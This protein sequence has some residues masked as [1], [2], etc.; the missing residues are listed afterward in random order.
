[1]KSPPRQPVLLEVCVASVEDAQSAQAG[2][3]QR[4]ELNAALALGGL[5]PSLGTLAEVKRT[6]SLPVMVMIRPRSGGF[7]YS[8]ADFLVMQ[9]DV[10]SALEQ[11]A[12]GI[13]FGILS[14][15]GDI[16][17]PRCRQIIHLAGQ[18]Q[19]VF[20]R[21]FDV[22]PDPHRALEQLVDLG[23]TRVMTSGQE[24]S[25]PKG[26]ALIAELIARAAGRIEI[27]PAGGINRFTVRDV[28]ARTRCKQ[29]H[30]SLRMK[31]R[32]TSVLARPGISFGSTGQAAEDCYDATDPAAVAEMVA[33]LADC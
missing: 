21:A 30:A 13:V 15:Q 19:I 27:L 5:T 23:V 20:H 22:T 9:R 14:D 1:M 12:D 32:D 10:D 29:V 28:V 24:E 33:L 26:A 4:I 6:V 17:M 7:A 18:R 8:P 3:A 31:K 25:A 11:R 2:G 16:D